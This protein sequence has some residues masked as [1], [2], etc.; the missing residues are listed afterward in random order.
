MN[1]YLATWMYVEDKEK[2]YSQVGKSGSESFNIVYWR[3]VYCFYKTSILTQKNIKYYFFTNIDVPEN[4]DGF[5]LKQFMKFNNIET[6]KL[7]YTYAPPEDWCDSWWVEMFE[8]DIL[9]YCKNIEGRWLILDVDCIMRK[10]LLPVFDIIEADGGINYHVGY[11]LEH[12]ING[13]TVKEEREI[14]ENVFKEAANDLHHRGGEFVGIRSD[15]IEEML[16][17]YNILY[18]DSIDKY[19]TGRKRLITEEHFFSLIFY[20]LGYRY[21]KGNEF[22]RRLWSAKE[23]DDIR[24]EDNTL[25]IWHLPA[26]K[27]RGFVSLFHFLRNEPDKDAYLAYLE[28]LLAVGAGEAGK[29]IRRRKGI[30]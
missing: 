25:A 2:L 8:F 13:L 27:K 26:E 28:E 7:Q 14:Y 1:N 20:R 21:A 9:N 11:S 16:S 10:S 15:M 6:V 23:F 18:K 5:N 17:L 22:I 3:C 4:V 24:I 30:K 12:N 29:Q 19:K